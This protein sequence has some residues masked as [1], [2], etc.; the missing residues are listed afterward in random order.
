[1]DSLSLE[2]IIMAV[3]RQSQVGCVGGGGGGGVMVADAAI[4]PN[5]HKHCALLTSCRASPAAPRATAA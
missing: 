1:M 4:S 3:R 2:E 5:K